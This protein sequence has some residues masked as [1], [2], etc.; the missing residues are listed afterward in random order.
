MATA[1]V[2]KKKESEQSSLQNAFMLLRQ[3]ISDA[4]IE[5]DEEV[6]VV[7]TA[8]LA[9]EHPLLVGPPGTAKSML[10][11]TL[12]KVFGGNTFSV[13]F[14]RFT[15]PEEVFGPISVQGL[16]QDQYRR[17]TTGKLPECQWGFLDEIF[18]ASSAILN[19]L[20]R[21]LNERV[22]ENGDGVFRPIPLMMCVAASN[23]WPGDDGKDLGALFDRFVL[24]KTVK[25]IRTEDG[26]RRLLFGAVD[27]T[28]KLTVSLTPQDVSAAQFDAKSFAWSDNAKEGMMEILTKLNE[29]GVFPGDRRQF[30]SVKVVKAY[31][32]L[33]GAAMVEREHLEILAHTLWDD[34]AEQP[35]KVAKIV[36][37]VANPIG[38]QITERLLMAEDVITKNTPAEAVPKLKEIQEYLESLPHHA[39]K[40]PAL[41]ILRYQIK[42]TY[43]KVLGVRA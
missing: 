31:A 6:D 26:R 5:R 21:A 19:T 25:P 3:Q 2:A 1:K 43:D 32:Y 33:C 30:K 10:L 9:G 13:L 24:R 27:H 4:L 20:L 41:G 12:L 38:A 14:N 7:L 28:P 29:E 16:K 39:K 8:L 22:Y 15:T 18:K 37:K 40:A 17:I 35:D 11:D 36:T 42:K 34:P 23:E